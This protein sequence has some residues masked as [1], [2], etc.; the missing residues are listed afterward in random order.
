MTVQASLSLATPADQSTQLATAAT[1]LSVTASG[2]DAP[3]SW[4]ISGQPAG[5][6]IDAAGTISGT[7]TAPPATYP[8]VV[9][10]TDQSGATRS[11]SFTWTVVP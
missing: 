10:V 7:P 4:A 6:S 5:L 2:G 11:A 9:S 1:P 8:A 3:Y